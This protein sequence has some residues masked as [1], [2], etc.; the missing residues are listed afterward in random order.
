LNELRQQINSLL[1]S[2]R[3]REIVLLETRT[4]RKWV[5]SWANI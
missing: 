4:P 5:A 3:P 2:G 1:K